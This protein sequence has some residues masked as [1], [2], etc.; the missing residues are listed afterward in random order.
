MKQSPKSTKL[1][2]SNL[3]LISFIIV[4]IICSFSETAKAKIPS[5][6]KYPQ[7]NVISEIK[8][9]ID[10]T[11]PLFPIYGSIENIYDKDLYRLRFTENGVL[12]ISDETLSS[13][14]EYIHEASL[15]SAETYK[16]FYKFSNRDLIYGS[17]YIEKGDYILKIN[18][19]LDEFN[20]KEYEESYYSFDLYFSPIEADDHGGNS[21]QKYS[22]TVIDHTLDEEIQINGKYLENDSGYSDIDI[23]KIIIP[24]L[25]YYKLNLDI[26]KPSRDKSAKIS[27][28]DS[29]GEEYFNDGNSLS[30]GESSHTILKP[31]AY[32]L[33]TQ[34]EE[35]FNYTFTSIFEPANAED[36]RIVEAS[37]I[38]EI[39]N[40]ALFK[41]NAKIASIRPIYNSAKQ[42]FS[43]NAIKFPIRKEIQFEGLISK[44]HS[45]L[46]SDDDSK[47]EDSL[48]LYSN[49]DQEKYITFLSTEGNHSLFRQ[50]FAYIFLDSYKNFNQTLKTQSIRNNIIDIAFNK[51]NNFPLSITNITIK[52]KNKNSKLDIYFNF[53]DLKPAHGRFRLNISP[54][55]V[56]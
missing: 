3:V 11:T 54:Y 53:G 31:G 10:I 40:P 21:I 7:I 39:K 14:P 9:A 22:D 45:T 52:R 15:F 46:I 34:G 50:I 48:C 35:E 27:L 32:T 19:R 49:N 37:L 38:Y 44:Y 6:F 26:K 20:T 5:K 13:D 47:S 36:L 33:I 18:R 23:F 12:K 25:G 41:Q 17:N 43:A 51:E 28:L 4:F 30:N 24:S 2:R 42:V 8:N 55:E 1:I 16:Q 29:N 56:K